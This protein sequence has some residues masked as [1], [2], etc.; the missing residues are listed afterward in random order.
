M[1][2][3]SLPKTVLNI[4]QDGGDFILNGK[5][6]GEIL[7]PCQ[8]GRDYDAVNTGT[9]GGQKASPGIF[10][11]NAFFGRQVQGFQCRQVEPGVGLGFF[12]VVARYDGIE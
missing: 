8:L 1:E 11:R 4:F 5:S 6:A 10:Y 3:D 9:R 7:H 2:V 12:A